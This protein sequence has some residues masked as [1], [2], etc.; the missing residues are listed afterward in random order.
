MSHATDRTASRFGRDR[1][2]FPDG[3]RPGPYETSYD[4]RRGYQQP[5]RRAARRHERAEGTTVLFLGRED[6]EP[7]AG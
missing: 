6:E 7:Q 4:V 3:P 2:V 5:L 1:D